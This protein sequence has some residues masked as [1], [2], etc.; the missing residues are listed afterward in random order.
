M[1]KSAVLNKHR[2]SPEWL[3]SPVPQFALEVLIMVLIA[4]HLGHNFSLLLLSIPA[5]TFFF[6]C[7]R[8]LFCFYLNFPPSI[9]ACAF[10]VNFFLSPKDNLHR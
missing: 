7:F 4:D 1:S 10:T 3:P 2:A 8:K 6:V 9:A 5:L